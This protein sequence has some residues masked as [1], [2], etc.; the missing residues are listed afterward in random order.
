M[1]P[2]L[3]LKSFQKE[4]VGLAMAIEFCK[5]DIAKQYEAEARVT[6]ST[7]GVAA[8]ARGH[9]LQQSFADATDPRELEVTVHALAQLAGVGFPA[10]DQHPERIWNTSIAGSPR[11][12]WASARPAVGAPFQVGVLHAH[13]G[14]ARADG[15]SWN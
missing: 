3:R 13:S 8:W 1:Q 7:E 6:R 15:A 4:E 9:L 10:T 5:K 2:L 11:T 14:D 12:R